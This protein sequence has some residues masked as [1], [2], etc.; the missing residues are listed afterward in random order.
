MKMSRIGWIGCAGGLV[1]A[2]ASF[3]LDT[4][5]YLAVFEIV[6]PWFLNI[7]LLSVLVFWLW[8]RLHAKIALPH[9]YL[10][11]LDDKHKSRFDITSDVCGIGRNPGNQIR[12]L[13]KSISRFHA[14]LIRDKKGNITIIDISSKNGLRVGSRVVGSC[15]LNEGDIIQVGNVRFKFSWQLENPESGQTTETIIDNVSARWD[16][17]R[18]RGQRAAINLKVQLYNDELG[19]INGTTREVGPNGAFVL[20]RHGSLSLGMRV[21]VIFPIFDDSHQRLLRLSG[22]IVRTEDDGVAI[23]ITDQN[24]VSRR[25]LQKTVEAVVSQPE[26]KAA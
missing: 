15:V 18:R 7:A 17:A 2:Q 11:K 20:I 19:W 12:L 14:E 4:G 21:D 3:A 25:L 1:Y 22:E 10:Y 23:R 6:P 26:S 24:L 9:A 8:W 16:D 5:E 13:S